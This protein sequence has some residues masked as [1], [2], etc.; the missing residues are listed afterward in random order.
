MQ[1]ARDRVDERAR[2]RLRGLRPRCSRTAW[3]D[4]DEVR[5]AAMRTPPHPLLASPLD[6]DPA[7]LVEL[8]LQADPEVA[9][10]TSVPPTARA[11]AAAWAEQTGGTARRAIRE[12]MHILDEVRDPPRPG[13]GRASRGGR[14][15]PIATRRLDAGVR[16]RGR[17]LGRHAGRGDR[18]RSHAARRSAGVAGRAAGVDGRG[19]A[20]RSPASSGSAPSTPRR[21]SGA[22]ATPAARWRR[23]AGARSRGERGGACSTP[24]STTRRRTRS[25][26]RSATS[27]TAD[28]EEIALERVAG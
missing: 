24:T 8:W 4:G 14:G 23:R 26:P 6:A 2:R 17:R 27:A 3:D 13:R 18:R 12:A 28:W 5:F 19:H 10:V 22:G 1:R 9:G 20:A 7:E 21:R 11:I 25:T 16:D 15:G